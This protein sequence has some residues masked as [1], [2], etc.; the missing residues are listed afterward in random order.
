MRGNPEESE[1]AGRGETRDQIEKKT[2]ERKVLG[3][4]FRERRRARNQLR[5]GQRRS[6]RTDGPRFLT[7]N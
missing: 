2:E 4:E 1:R 3:P 6:K 5:N 7:S